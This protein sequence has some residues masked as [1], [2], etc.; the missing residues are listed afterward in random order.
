MDENW[1]VSERLDQVLDRRRTALLQFICGQNIDRQGRI[2]G[3]AANEGAG[4]HDLLYGRRTGALR[5]RGA[6]RH[7]TCGDGDRER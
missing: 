5:L 2:L 7:E 6:R 3:R 4:D 1:L